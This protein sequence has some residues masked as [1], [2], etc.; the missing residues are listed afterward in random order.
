M[1]FFL[2]S[3][4]DQTFS[5]LNE[6]KD[7]L[8]IARSND[9]SNEKINTSRNSSDN[10]V[11]N[12]IRLHADIPVSGDD[13]DPE[14]SSLASQ[15]A[16]A[17]FNQF[18]NPMK[19]EMMELVKTT[20][21][22]VQDYIM[23]T[24]GRKN[25]SGLSGDETF[26]IT[27]AITGFTSGSSSTSEGSSQDTAYDII[28]DEGVAVTQRSTMNFIGSVVT[29]VD[30]AAQSRTDITITGGT[31]YDDSTFRIYDNADITK[32]IAFEASSITTGTT[33]TATMP[34]AN[35][36]FVNT[37]DG[38]IRDANTSTFTTTKIST[39]SKSLLNSAIVYNDQTNT[40]GDFNQTF[41]DN[42]IL[43]ESPDTLTPITIVNSQQTLARNLLIPILTADR[44]FVVTGETSQITIG[45]EVTGASTNLTDSSIIVRNN[46]SNTFGAFLQ[47]FSSSTL[48]LPVS[49]TP[50]VTVDGDIAFDSLVT[51]FSTGLIKFFGNE[52]QAIVTMPIGQFTSPT[53]GNVV[54]YNATNDEFELVA[55]GGGANSL[56]DLTDVTIT[57][58]TI[59]DLLV[60]DVEGDWINRQ[61][62]FTGITGLGAQAIALDM[63]SQDIN[64]ANAITALGDI[65]ISRGNTSG[66]FEFISKHTVPT[67]GDLIADIDFYDDNDLN[68]QQLYADISA[69]IRD[70][71]NTSLDGG[72]MFRVVE[73]SSLV[74]YIELNA[75]ALQK[76][77]FSRN[78]DMTTNTI[79]NAVL[80][81]PTIANFTNATHNHQNAVGGGQLVATSALTATGTKDNTTFLRGDDT[82]AVPAGGGTGTIRL[83]KLEG[84]TIST[85]REGLNFADTGT[86][87]FTVTDDVGN[88]EADVIAAIVNDSVV[89]AQIGTHTSTKITITAKGQLN[90]AIV[91]NDQANIFGDFAQ[92]FAD[93]Q[94]FIQNPAATFEYQIIASA[95]TADRTLTIPLLTGNDVFV[96]EA[97][98]QTLTNK[99]IDGDLNTILDINETQMNVS[100]G[101]SGT[102]LTS[103]GVGV[104]PTY[105][106][107]GGGANSL[108]DLTDVTITTAAANQ[109]LI[110]NAGATAM[111]NK[112]MSGDATLASDGTLS[113]A[114]NFAT[115]SNNLSFFSA[116]TSAQLAGVISDETGTGALVFGTSPTLTTPVISSIVNTGTLTLPTSTDTLIG[117]ATTDTLTNK[118]FDA[119]GTGNS[120]SNVDVADLAN[121]TDGELITWDAAGVAA[122]VATGTAGQVLTSNGAGAAPT[123][124]TGGG[125]G[126]VFTWTADHS[127][128]RFNLENTGA[129]DFSLSGPTAFPANTQP[130]ITFDTSLTPDAIVVNWPST[131]ELRFHVAGVEEYTF[132]NTQLDMNL[133]SINNCGGLVMT[134]RIQG[135]KGSDVAASGTITL[136]D[137][138]YFDITGTSVTIDFMT[139]TNWQAGS[140]VT[141]QFDQSSITVTSSAGSP[142]ANTAE[143]ALESGSNFVSQGGDTLS[144][145]FDG[146][147][148]REIGRG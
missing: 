80:S 103:N 130:F 15:L 126:E 19:S 71:T 114:S 144:I 4:P 142:P 7:F 20:K 111:E 2:L 102:V 42:R 72:L 26:G 120:L 18:Q 56:N 57:P 40:F 137:A 92:T 77:T 136:G 70:P 8:N 41:K 127:A 132:S 28:Q 21:K 48:R 43:I 9:D 118:T 64:S 121:G 44:N 133:N 131:N 113:I 49:T 143:F 87:N 68:T 124:Q 74:K 146:T 123:F 148:W 37:I 58:P 97:F 95:I 94:L 60:S 99:T 82:W 79:E 115:S 65:T 100:V 14:L 38:L 104:A 33:K 46:Q 27:S 59:N 110:Y 23:E 24:Y 125:G 29:A 39:T 55:G 6:T 53:D 36:T 96:T 89:D 75:T 61:G 85:D 93:N 30:N 13:N 106:T 140:R 51:D 109:I 69:N 147:F 135:S 122:T 54:T 138:N 50:S 17:I 35:I 66:I 90:S 67:A 88:N 1:V 45:T 10:Y 91:Y 107:V 112:T 62:T 129:I 98:T 86:I 134:G 34:D 119:N 105:Q 84:V 63:N 128:A 141:L 47:N 81:S 31:T 145:I 32:Q 3:T 108:N 16:A 5:T 52:E 11:A 12:Q 101:A 117:K 116:T 76:I 73:N 139:T 78:L 25:P 83:V 22:S